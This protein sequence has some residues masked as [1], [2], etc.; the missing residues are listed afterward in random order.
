[1]RYD[2]FIVSTSPTLN[3]SITTRL[4]GNSN[5]YLLTP[6]GSFDIMDKSRF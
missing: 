5:I 2:L 6:Y 1:M 4:I 3:L